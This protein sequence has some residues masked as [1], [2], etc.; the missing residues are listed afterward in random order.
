MIPEGPDVPI[1]ILAVLPAGDVCWRPSGRAVDEGQANLGRPLC[2][3][4]AAFRNEGVVAQIV[5]EG[6]KSELRV[7]GLAFVFLP[8]V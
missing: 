2:Y 3:R 4:Q 5:D 7:A 8:N 1:A 6:S